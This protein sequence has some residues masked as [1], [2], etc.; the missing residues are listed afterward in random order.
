MAHG[1]YSQADGRAHSHA[2][3]HATGPLDIPPGQ[4]R[5]IRRVLA[6]LVIPLALATGI[7]L[8]VLWPRGESPVGSMPLYAEGV[9]QV[10]G[11]IVSIGTLD[12]SG[13]TPVTME[14]SGVE[15]GVHVPLEIVQ[16]GLDVGDE[17]RAVFDPRTIGEGNS[18][19]FVDYV[20]T[21]PLLLLLGTYVV[22]VALV[23]RGKGIRALL[24]LGVS[25]AVVGAFMIPALAIGRPPVLVILVGAAAMMFASLY[26]AHGVSVRTT[27]AVLGTFAGLVITTLLAVWSVG[28]VELSGTLGDEALLLTSAVPGLNM[29]ALLLCGMIL[30]GLGALNDVTIT[31][32]SSVWELHAANPSLSRRRLF[33]QGM[34]VGRDHIASTV[35]TLVFAYVGSALPLLIGASLIN[36]PVQDLLQ[37]GQIA[38]EI[39][40]TLVASVGLVLA[41]PLTTAIAA[42]LARIAPGHRDGVVGNTGG[43]VKTDTAKGTGHAHGAAGTERESVQGVGTPNDAAAVEGRKGTKEREA[44]ADSDTAS[45]L[46]ISEKEADL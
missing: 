17:I 11:K 2:H 45:Q 21:T 23:A 33:Q 10:T 35:Y 22:C 6:A 43:A 38:E 3:S 12:E 41:I 25:L 28:T 37:A 14:V 29:R 20:R 7:A 44:A 27:T 16:N 34:A 4:L 31:Q 24:G 5:T 39:A 46:E 15:V 18:Y 32:V 8:A 26:M 36:R 42:S 13:Q 19:T 30:A 9:E 40:R 1:E